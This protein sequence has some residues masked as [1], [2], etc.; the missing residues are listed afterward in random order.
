MKKLINKLPKKFKWTLH[1][2]VAHPLMEVVYL[3]GYSKLSEKIHELTIP[4]E[5]DS[6]E[7]INRIFNPERTE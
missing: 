3:L 2:V 7:N 1:N 6:Q 5:L 4:D